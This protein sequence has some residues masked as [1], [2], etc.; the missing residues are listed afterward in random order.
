MLTDIELKVISNQHIKLDGIDYYFVD[1]MDY[2]IFI[3]EN[4]S[5]FSHEIIASYYCPLSV[6][7]RIQKDK[8]KKTSWGEIAFIDG[9][10]AID[11][12]CPKIPKVLDSDISIFC[13]KNIGAVL[14]QMSE[15]CD[16]YNAGANVDIKLFRN[17]CRK[18]GLDVNSYNYFSK[19]PKDGII[20]KNG[21]GIN[22]F[23]SHN[24]VVLC[25]PNS[26]K[27]ISQIIL[28]MMQ[29]Q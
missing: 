18:E 9:S 22:Y 27:R 7:Y 1:V 4:Q 24:F 21:I 10:C 28:N 20:V 5:D 3:P 14:P 8:I 23:D 25:K 13:T 17:R 2:V 29:E 26:S 6:D 12:F 16:S 15:F 19:M 11:L